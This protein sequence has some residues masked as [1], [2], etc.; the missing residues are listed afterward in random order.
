MTN[1]RLHQL[2]RRVRVNFRVV[3]KIIYP[4]DFGIEILEQITSL[5]IDSIWYYHYRGNTTLYEGYFMIL[6][7][8]KYC[9]YYEAQIN[10]YFD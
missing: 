10:K 5:T 7:V 2:E 8:R 3:N 4:K 6:R 9:R 1:K